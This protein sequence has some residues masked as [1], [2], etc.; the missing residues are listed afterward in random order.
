VIS[1]LMLLAGSQVAGSVSQKA[2]L[3]NREDAI[4]EYPA[5]ALRNHVEGTTVMLV[6]VKTDG[7]VKDCQIDSSSGS[8]ELDASSCKQFRARARFS[9][10]IDDQGRPVEVVIHQ[11]IS[12]KIPQER[13]WPVGEWASR[14]V[15]TITSGG[16]LTSCTKEVESPIA[17]RESR[18]ADF[19]QSGI[20]MMMTLR[21]DR[22]F[23][24][25]LK[26][27]DKT[28]V[29]EVHFYPGT[30]IQAL[31][32]SQDGQ[33]LVAR[34]R[35]QFDIGPDGRVSNCRMVES[36]GVRE[37]RQNICNDF[38]DGPFAVNSP[39]TPPQQHGQG[40]VAIYARR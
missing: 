7:R 18:C 4:R 36:I 17:D 15:L 1:A 39:Q 37:L 35:S 10:A 12:W 20:P 30:Q 11:A 31:P 3:L 32:G 21:N 6:T 38:F 27:G 29:F 14:S 9:P 28:V 25:R 24:N 40:V 22:T 8:V 13:P 19:A 23:A 26:T 34:M 33:E 2:H 16:H 5:D